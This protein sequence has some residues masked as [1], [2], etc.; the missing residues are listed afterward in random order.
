MASG[1][2]SIYRELLRLHFNDEQS[3]CEDGILTEVFVV[4]I[5]PDVSLIGWFWSDS[6]L[7]EILHS[8][9]MIYDQVGKINAHGDGVDFEL[10]T[11]GWLLH[12]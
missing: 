2:C 10:A 6:T 5:N 12:K 4:F 11:I 3:F 9:Q 7:K 1:G 8:Y